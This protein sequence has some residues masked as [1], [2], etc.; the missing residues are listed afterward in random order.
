MFTSLEV[1]A[2]LVIGKII[3]EILGLEFPNILIKVKT[4]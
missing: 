2:I 3:M 1:A 4:C